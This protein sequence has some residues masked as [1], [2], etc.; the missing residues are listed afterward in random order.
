MSTLCIN[1][2]HEYAEDPLDCNSL[3][4]SLLPDRHLPLHQARLP[5]L[6]GYYY[7]Y[8]SGTI[9]LY[10]QPFK[11]ETQFFYEKEVDFP[12]SANQLEAA[13]CKHILN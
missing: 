2:Y 4:D 6:D 9:T 11:N 5:P 8:C 13:A 10:A 1:S 7:I 12:I 3:H